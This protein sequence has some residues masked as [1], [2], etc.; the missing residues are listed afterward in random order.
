MRVGRRPNF[1]I[2]GAAKCGTTAWV[3][4]LSR[5]PD[6]FFNSLKETQFFATDFPEYRQVRSLDDFLDLYA[7]A[8]DAS[9]LG[10]ASPMHLRSEAAAANIR[11]FDPD[12]KILILLREVG[13]FI[14]SWHNQV[15]LM[16]PGAE[17]DL[18]SAWARSG[19][20]DRNAPGI[21][22][23]HLV[24]Y[25]SMGAFGDQVARYLE[26]FRADQVCVAWMEDWSRNPA[27]FYRFLRRFLGL[28]PHPVGE[29]TPVNTARRNRSRL[30]A[31]LLTER[32]LVRPATRF[33]RWS[34]IGPL[35]VHRRLTRANTVEAY[36]VPAADDVLERIRAHYREDQQRLR[37]MLEQ[38]ATVY[39]PVES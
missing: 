6:V 16:V 30:V 10:D 28:R 33:L 11:S 7:E 19:S 32:R 35:G 38:R 23:P 9:V 34:G 2:V 39:R 18:A 5:H 26:L 1:F 25:K 29:F 12:A 22:N 27:D 17:E 24:D 14:A 8:G 20:V 37:T 36:A 13:D 15:L 4:Y 21:R 31:R 3:E